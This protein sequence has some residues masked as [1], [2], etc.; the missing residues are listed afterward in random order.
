MYLDLGREWKNNMEH[1]SNSDTSCNW[2]TRYSHQL[3]GK[4]SAGLGNKMKNGNHATTTLL[5]RSEY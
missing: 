3:I 4:R 2:C 5:N 1:E